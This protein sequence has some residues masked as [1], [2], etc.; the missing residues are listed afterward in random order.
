M[1]YLLIL[2]S[3]MNGLIAINII[4]NSVKSELKKKITQLEKDISHIRSTNP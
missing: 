2:L 1:K 3:K 4:I